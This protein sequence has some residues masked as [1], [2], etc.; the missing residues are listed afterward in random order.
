VTVDAA[1]SNDLFFFDHQPLRAVPLVTQPDGTE[2]KQSA[3][4]SHNIDHA[5]TFAFATSFRYG[6]SSRLVSVTHDA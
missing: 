4:I 5:F 2:D 6:I 3:E 1:V